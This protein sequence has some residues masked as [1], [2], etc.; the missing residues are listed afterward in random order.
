[1]LPPALL[2]SLLLPQKYLNAAR[3]ATQ[4]TVVTFGAPNIGDS[5]FAGDYN[6]RVNTRNIQFFADIVTQV[7]C[8]CLTCDSC[9]L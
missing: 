4:V 9:Q 5:A 2:P 3:S 6:R 7:S 1:L 8:I